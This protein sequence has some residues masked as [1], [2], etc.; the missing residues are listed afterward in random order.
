[1][2]CLHC[3]KKIS[4]ESMESSPEKKGLLIL[5]LLLD[6]SIKRYEK[7]KKEVKVEKEEKKEEEDI[8]NF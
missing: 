4:E 2:V 1:M 6:S 5:N 8:D 7:E 3:P